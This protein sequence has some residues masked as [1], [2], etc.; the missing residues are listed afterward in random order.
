MTGTEIKNKA[1][2]F[3]GLNI[4]DALALDGINEAIAWLGSMGIDINTQAYTS[5]TEETVYALP[6]DNIKVIKVETTSEEIDELVYYYNYVIDGT[7][8]RFGDDGDYTLY[9]KALTLLSTIGTSLSLHLL[10][11][12]C[13]VDYLKGFILMREE[14]DG[15]IWMQ[16]FERDSVKTYRDLMGNKSGP[17]SIRVIRHA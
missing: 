14:K 3:T 6:A 17:Q 2:R 8:I 4:S 1:E 5:S 9:Y 16:K 11:Q 13:I 15:G 7:N 12:Y 10:L